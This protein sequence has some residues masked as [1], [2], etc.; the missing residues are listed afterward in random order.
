[1]IAAW[2]FIDVLLAGVLAA[3]V[4]WLMRR[5]LA[6]TEARPGDRRRAAVLLGLAGLATCAPVLAVTP[7]APLVAVALLVAP[8]AALVAF[9]PGADLL[10]DVVVGVGIS[11]A[12][13]VLGGVTMLA[14]GTWNAEMFLGVLAF[15]AV[16]ALV[17][18]GA[19][20]L[21]TGPGTADRSGATA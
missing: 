9:R 13:L 7:A 2:L 3:R 15:V 18:R 17:W 8:G 11:V 21:L 20:L 14:L 19:A 1:M 5:R 16:P 6:S 10:D 12:V 4:R